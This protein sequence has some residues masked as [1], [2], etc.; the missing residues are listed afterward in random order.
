MPTK[1]AVRKD[2]PDSWIAVNEGD[3]IDGTVIDVTEAWSDVRKDGSFYPLLTIRGT[4][5]G[6][7]P[8]SELKVHCFGAV[9]YNE[10][11]KHRPEIGERIIIAYL[12]SGRAKGKGMNPPE[13]Y[14]L[15]CPD[16]RNQAASA[17]ERIG[18]PQQRQ[19][20]P[21]PVQSELGEDTEDLPF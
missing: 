2:H 17:Y 7:K 6:Y 21:E 10:V 3:S 8:D 18:G 16:R 14:R 20:E 5:T 12:G 13:L 15:S 11:M 1:E 19:T 9:L 4:A